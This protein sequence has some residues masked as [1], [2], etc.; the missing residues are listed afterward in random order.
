MDNGHYH[1]CPTCYKKW[2][3]ADYCDPLPGLGE[4]K[5]K[6]VAPHYE[7]APCEREHDRHHAPPVVTVDPARLATLERIAEAAREAAET[8]VSRGSH[9]DRCGYCATCVLYAALAELVKP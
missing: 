5:G 2:L 4:Y 9:T 7:C 8:C 6:P 1:S 3:C